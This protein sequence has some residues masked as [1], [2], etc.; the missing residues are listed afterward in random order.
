M[1]RRW[2]TFGWLAALLCCCA[3]P[4]LACSVG[5]TSASATTTAASGATATSGPA[6]CA[7]HATTTALA[8]VTGQQVTG[9]IPASASATPLSHFVYPLG[10]QDE[11]AVGNAPQL[12]FMA[13]APDATRLAVAVTQVVPFHTEYNPYIVDTSTHAVTHVPLPAPI[14]VPSED[15]PRR[16]FAWANT[17][18]L[19]IFTGSSVQ[20]YD[21]TTNTLSA[22]PGITGAVEGVVRCSTLFYSAYPGLNTVSSPVVSEQIIRYN[23]TT[24]SQIGS[25]ITIGNAGTWGGAE[26]HVEYGGWDVSS[27]GAHLAYQNLSLTETAGNGGLNESSHW[28]AANADGSGATSILPSAT[29]NTMAY[30]SISPDGSHVAVTNAN[31]TPNVLSGPLSG[32]ATRF[33]DS[34]SGYSQIAWSADSSGFYAGTSSDP[35]SPV[36]V[37]L[38]PIGAGGHATGSTSVAGASAPASLP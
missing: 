9:K 8:W 38:Y 4:M 2:R 17:H 35:F 20:R 36:A 37:A 23:L 22:L 5:Q 28:F 32:G 18:T 24:S 13:F 21:I 27:D 19:L 34:P 16:L 12:T 14:D 33:Y 11:G 26:G 6:P 31:P 1:L 30:V 10:I 15:T 3:A 7:T 25:P 29:A